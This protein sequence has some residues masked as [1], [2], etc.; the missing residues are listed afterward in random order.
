MD[1]D[2]L[3][4]AS[5]PARLRAVLALLYASNIAVAYLLMLVGLS[6]PFADSH[7]SRLFPASFLGLLPVQTAGCKRW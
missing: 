2:L 7:T 6:L 5:T 4:R 3:R 1:T